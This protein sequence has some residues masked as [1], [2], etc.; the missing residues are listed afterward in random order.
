MEKTLTAGKSKF[1]SMET[2]WQGV[3]TM[4]WAE[5]AAKHTATNAKVAKLFTENRK[6][7][8][9]WR[10]EKKGTYFSIEICHIK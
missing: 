10:G 1:C 9:L 8:H 7:S 6:F 3:G 2:S 5:A 4:I